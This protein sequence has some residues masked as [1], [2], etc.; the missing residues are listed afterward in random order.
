MRTTLPTPSFSSARSQAAVAVLTLLLAGTALNTWA[1]GEM[2]S[3]TIFGS[4]S[5]PYTYSLSFADAAGATSPI[6]SVWYAWTAA[7]PPYFYLP[8]MPSTAT[9]PTGWTANIDGNS[10][11]FSA[12][13]SAYDIQPGHSLSGF[14]YTA[15]FT[16][17]QLAGTANS[18]LSVAYSGAIE[19]SPDFS[20][21]MFTVSIVPEPGTLSLLTLGAGFLA[22]ALRRQ[23]R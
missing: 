14:S 11:Q 12:T 6:G 22:V 4:G 20:G 15:A 2:P 16:P 19:G 10:I 17:A 3:G 7:V 23:S 21:V 9:P 1:Q 5:G 18:G 8:M 13:S